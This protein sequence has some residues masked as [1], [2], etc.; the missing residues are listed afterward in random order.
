MQEIQISDPKKDYT[1]MTV[2]LG[3]SDYVLTLQQTAGP[4][5]TRAGYY[6]D[7]RTPAGEAVALN[8]RVRLGDVLQDLHAATGISARLMAVDTSRNHR[9][10]E[11]RDIG[12]RVRL[13]VD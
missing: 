13:V 10:P 7:I 11:R 2:T 12:D 3:G 9:E 1:T 5:T 4:D 6:L 8:R